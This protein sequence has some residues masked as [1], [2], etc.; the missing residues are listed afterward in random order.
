MS[1]TSVY[2]NWP[3][4]SYSLIW[5]QIAQQCYDFYFL[6]Y[7]KCAKKKGKL[8]QNNLY[9]FVLPLSEK[10]KPLHEFTVSYIGNLDKGL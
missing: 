10:I 6:Q 5:V 4:N 8:Y 9:F 3:R 1:Q 7:L 2:F